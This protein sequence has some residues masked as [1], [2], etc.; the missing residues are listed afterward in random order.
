MT[1]EPIRVLVVD[2]DYRVAGLHVSF[3]G[4]VPGF[5]AVGRAHTATDALELTERLHPTLVLLD[6][7]L[8]DGD[9]L[10]VARRLLDTHPSPAVILISAANDHETVKQAVQLGAFHYL[11]KPFDLAVLTDLLTS[12]RQAHTTMAELLDGA[13]QQDIN[14]VFAHRR[15]TLPTTTPPRS[16]FAPTTQLVY[17]II[18]TQGPRLSAADV[19][20]AAGISRATA[21]R[22]LT[23]LEHDGAI[24]LELHYGAAGRPEHRYS[25]G[26]R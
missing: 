2:D 25:A 22:S 12:F 16:P 5:V 21:Q 7:Y 4:R 3:V 24:T 8:P 15:P 20:Q 17:R 9:G 19:A 10:D 23:K 18:A 26:A 14:R 6:V 13:D 1:G 11:V